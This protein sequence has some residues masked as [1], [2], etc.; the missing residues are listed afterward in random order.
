MNRLSI[1]S[2]DY[3]G[4][5]FLLILLLT[6]SIFILPIS[7]SAQGAFAYAP[8][9]YTTNYDLP[10]LRTQLNVDFQE[11]LESAIAKNKTWKKLMD[12][13]KLAV[14]LVDLSDMSRV[15]FAQINGDEMMYAA[16]LP[17][18][19]ILLTAMDALE[20][21]ELQETPEIRNDLRLMISKSSNQASTRMIDRL[22]YD[23]IENVLTSDDYKLYDVQNGG[24]LWVGK[25]YAA[26]GP[27]NPDPLQGLSHA[28]TATQISRFYY[29]MLQGKLVC[30]ERSEE[31]MACMVDPQLH[32]KFVNS[33][34]K[35]APNAKLFRK[36]GSW[37]T[38]H[39]DSIMVWGPNRQYI[40]T[41]LVN[42]SNGEQIMRQLVYEVE[43]VLD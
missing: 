10:P 42:D 15:R 4:S 36:S 31:M 20:K 17:K 19:A 33:L 18:I 24:G 22:G 7:L 38:F 26:S 13:K 2:R 41:A 37:S 21:G 32:H 23:R 43:K 16:S 35:I 9:S 28:A 1:T 14:G 30:K 34:D 6:V 40:L 3:F 29:M 25:R 39:S 27:R 8:T 12:Q 5:H 11:H